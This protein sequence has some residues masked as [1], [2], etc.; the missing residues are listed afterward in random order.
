MSKKTPPDGED[1]PQEPVQS[2]VPM[3]SPLAVTQGIQAFRRGDM[4]LY[5]VRGEPE[6][7][8]ELIGELSRRG[9]RDVV[10]LVSH[11]SDDQGTDEPPTEAEVVERP[12]Q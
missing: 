7:V 10:A 8:I 11:Q 5:T 9:V 1:Q 3:Y 2:L 12:E 6:Q 4:I